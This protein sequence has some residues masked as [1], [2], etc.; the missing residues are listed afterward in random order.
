MTAFHTSSESSPEPAG[1][2]LGFLDGL[3]GVAILLV[4]GFHYFS[5]FSGGV[6]GIYPYGDL[7]A[8]V[9]VFQYGYYGVHLFFAI[10][11]FV[12]VLS[13]EHSQS[14]ID[15]AFKRFARL[16]PTMLLCSTITFV[17]L[18]IWPMFG[19]QQW[20]NFLPSLSFID[21]LAWNRLIPTLKADWMDGAYWTLFV[22]VRFYFWVAV[23]YWVEGRL[24]LWSIA[25]FSSITVFM[26][27]FL[28]S[29]GNA[30]VADL[31]QMAAIAKY[32]PWFLLGIAARH[33]FQGKNGLAAA[34][35][36]LA[37]VQLLLLSYSG[38]PK[39]DIAVFLMIAALFLTVNFGAAVRS[40]LEVRWLVLVGVA[41]YSLYLLHQNAGLT[42]IS[43]LSQLLGLAGPASLVV[44]VLVLLG[45]RFISGW[46][47]RWWESP[48]NRFLVGRAM[49]R[50]RNRTMPAN[51]AAIAG[52]PVQG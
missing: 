26:H 14:F 29:V 33:L 5:R 31:L 38:L 4:I 3:R 15:F 7:L 10:S 30:Y 37:G 39:A 20:A 35:G 50:G 18:S 21:P 36:A 2:R 13:L 45:M 17:V 6:P 41:S 28:L 23:F 22:E 42:L 9:W 19:P 46:I 16:W 47:Y 27:V 40:M 51:P 34:L 52:G 24:F 25:V 44:A 49:N 11:G 32:W 8:D 43:S 12:I 48:L 1:N